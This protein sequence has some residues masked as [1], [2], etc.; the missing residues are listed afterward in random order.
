MRRAATATMVA[1]A[2]ALLA[3]ALMAQERQAEP[4]RPAAER[5]T[6]PQ[7]TPEQQAF[8]DQEKELRKQILIARLELQLA[9]AKE[10]PEPEI[11][12]KAERFYS[13]MGTHHAF[14]VKNRGVAQQVR[15]RAR[16]EWQRR[17]GGG[18]QGELGL[19]RGP[20][21]GRG[22]NQSG[23]GGPG[24][25]GQRGMGWGGG[26]GLSDQGQGRVRGMG[27]RG[28]P[29]SREQQWKASPDQTPAGEVQPD[30]LPA[31]PTPE[32]PPAEAPER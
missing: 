32:R 21:G 3:S 9:E 27:G 25:R 5:Q 12:A 15:Q 17:R 13:L 30:T 22:M 8:V 29:G 2:M 28:G 16:Q 23:R 19:R 18:A 4:A 14:L 26:Q 10:A 1:A 11:A 6:A 24:P 31:Q 7:L 20:R